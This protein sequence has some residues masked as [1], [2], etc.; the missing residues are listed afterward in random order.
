MRGD[1]WELEL[2]CCLVLRI[3]LMSR[4]GLSVLPLEG[5]GGS[6]SFGRSEE[7]GRGEFKP[8]GNV[9]GD[10]SENTGAFETLFGPRGVSM[11]SGCVA[12]RV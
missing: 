3:S 4:V 11:G 9:D 8:L 1:D 6:V 10:G 7:D 5:D 2:P 12:T